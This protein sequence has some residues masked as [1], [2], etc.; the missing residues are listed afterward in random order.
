M[1]DPETFTEFYARRDA[2][3]DENLHLVDR[4]VAPLC[5]N[6]R[7]LGSLEGEDLRQEGRI[8]LIRAAETFD[9][10]AGTA[11]S[12]WATTCILSA[13][14]DA[15]RDA[16]GTISDDDLQRAVQEL[17]ASSEPSIS[18]STEASDAKILVEQFLPQL[19]KN[20]PDAGRAIRLHFFSELNKT[21]VA[22]QMGISKVHAG[23]LIDVGL[24]WL[25]GAANRPKRPHRTEAPPPGRKMG[26]AEA[27]AHSFA[28]HDETLR[29]LAAH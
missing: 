28:L 15:I 6:R 26:Y 22:A 23:R 10:C 24:N 25:R 14:K 20:N 13:I 17:Q 29:R 8:G 5:L 27:K 16:S 11:F 19:E 9:D 4:I 1:P 18:D 2:L 21:E 12:S 7:A 3:V